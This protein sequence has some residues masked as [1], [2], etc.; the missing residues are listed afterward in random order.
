MGGRAGAGAGGPERIG[1]SGSA[2]SSRIDFSFFE[3]IFN[4]KTIPE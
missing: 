4:A 2:R 3:F 1:P